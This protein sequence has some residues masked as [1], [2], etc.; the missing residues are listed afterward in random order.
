MRRTCD[1][2]F[3]LEKTRIAHAVSWMP[4]RSDHVCLYAP[5][6]PGGAHTNA[7]AY[8]PHIFVD[9]DAERS[10]MGCY[11]RR[12]LMTLVNAKSG[13]CES[14]TLTQYKAIIPA[15]RCARLI[16]H[17]MSHRLARPLDAPLQTPGHGTREGTS[18]QLTMYHHI[19]KSCHSLYGMSLLPCSPAGIASWRRKIGLLFFFFQ[20]RL[21]AK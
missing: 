8:R 4:E 6:R 16:R 19:W 9:Y 17:T 15:G 2:R 14:E 18:L 7:R 5:G 3:V 12:G 1:G 10:R 11:G 21:L 20:L 13:Q